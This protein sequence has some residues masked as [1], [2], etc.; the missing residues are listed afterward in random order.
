MRPMDFD[1]SADQAALAQGT[2][3]LLDGHSGPAQLRAHIERGE[4]YSAAIWRAMAEQGWC[5]VAVPEDQGG[6]GLG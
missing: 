2:R 5:E 6:L 3:D 1:L 4:P